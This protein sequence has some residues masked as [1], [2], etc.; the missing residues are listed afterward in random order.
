MEVIFEVESRE[1]CMILDEG[2]WEGEWKWNEPVSGLSSL[3]MR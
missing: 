1:G 2:V 3:R